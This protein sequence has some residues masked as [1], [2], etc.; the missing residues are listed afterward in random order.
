VEGIALLLVVVASFVA[1][2][3]VSVGFGHDSR[4]AFGTRQ[5]ILS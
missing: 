5:G 4:D 2:G 3:L 1:L